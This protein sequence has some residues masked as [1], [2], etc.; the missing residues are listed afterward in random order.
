M[1]FADLQKKLILGIALSLGLLIEPLAVMANQA[2]GIGV[3]PVPSAAVHR[4]PSG[5]VKHALRPVRKKSAIKRTK[6]QRSTL[7]AKKQLSAKKKSA[8]PKPVRPP[9]DELGSMSTATLAPGVVHKTHRGA[10]NI[11]ILDV[12]L[13][14]P[15]IEVKPVLA[16]ETFNRLD[17]VRDQAKKVKA[18]AAVNANYFKRDGTP[19]GTLV[20]DGEWISGPLYDRISMGITDAGKVLVDRMNLHGTIETSNPQVSSMWVNNINQPRRSGVKLMAYT[21]R[22][23]NQVKMAYAG[24]LVAVDS[25]G[26]VVDKSTQIM[27][28]PYGGFVLSDTKNSPVNKLQRGDL[29]YMQWHT[30][31]QNWSNVTQAVSGGPTLIR[32]GKLYVDLKDQNF[33]KNWTSNSIHQRTA[34]GVTANH[35]L[36]LVT[37]EGVHTLWDVAKLLKKLGCVEAMNLDGGGSTTMVLNGKIVTRNSKTPQRRVAASLA[38]LPRSARSEISARPANNY[39]PSADPG[40]IFNT[41][42]GDDSVGTAFEGLAPEVQLAEPVANQINEK[43]LADTKQA[44]EP[45]G[46]SCDVMEPE[47][48]KV[49]ILPNQS[50]KNKKAKIR[51][52]LDWMK[53]FIP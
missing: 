45:A 7:K 18:I 39:V 28:I 43:V 6:I 53:K 3:V 20:I 46:L 50:K 44:A 5:R 2:V 9:Q 26:R 13:N 29:V 49:Q 17:E 33:R 31:P 15:D 52:H 22:W 32:N 48:S 47:H 1:Q 19:L 37:V 35:H 41:N 40:D 51:K 11:N 4:L 27:A 25:T 14:N 23:G 36:I 24:T 8:P 30:K 42:A 12:D 38:I 16:G 34:L 21:R 10:L